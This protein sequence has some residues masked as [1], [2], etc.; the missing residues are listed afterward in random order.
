MSEEDDYL[1]AHVH[2]MA[3]YKA[4]N[5][6]YWNFRKNKSFASVQDRKFSPLWNTGA[7]AWNG[8]TIP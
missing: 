6:S 1:R 2:I 5:H 8:K 7:A 4:I 3:Y